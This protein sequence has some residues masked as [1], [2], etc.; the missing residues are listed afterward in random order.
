MWNILRLGSI[1]NIA[2]LTFLD[3][4]S[5]PSSLQKAIELKTAGEVEIAEL[6]T[7]VKEV[8][9]RLF[10]ESINREGNHGERED[11]GSAAQETDAY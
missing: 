2:P 9:D 11:S 5:L 4:K 3:D 7:T 8:L 1:S 10:Q 6:N